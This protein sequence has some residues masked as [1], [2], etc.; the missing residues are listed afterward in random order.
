MFTTLLKNVE[1]IYKSTWT[2]LVI[3]KNIEKIYITIS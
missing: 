2:L 1:K 3:Y